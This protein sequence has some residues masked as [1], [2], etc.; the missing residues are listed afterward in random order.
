MSKNSLKRVSNA[1]A[2][3]A[4]SSISLYGQQL[5][6]LANLVFNF[7]GS[8]DEENYK[9]HLGQLESAAINIEKQVTFLLEIIK[10]EKVD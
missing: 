4:S 5:A 2:L 7:S 9:L 8:K 6:Q 3:V 10:D 1:D